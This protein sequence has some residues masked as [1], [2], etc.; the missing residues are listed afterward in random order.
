[1]FTDSK[2]T[3]RLVRLLCLERTLLHRPLP[4]RLLLAQDHTFADPPR[5]HDRDSRLACH[6]TPKPLDSL[7]QRLVCW[8]NGDGSVSTLSLLCP[9]ARHC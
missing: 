4:P 7:W 5:P 6:P 9:Y 1:M 3:E 2:T 8:C